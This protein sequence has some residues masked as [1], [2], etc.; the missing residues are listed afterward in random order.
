M[1]D[2]PQNSTLSWQSG[3]PFKADAQ[4]KGRPHRS[5]PSAGHSA[6]LRSAASQTTAYHCTG[7]V[8]E[9]KKFLGPWLVHISFGIF[10]GVVSGYKGASRKSVSHTVR[11]GVAFAARAK[12]GLGWNILLSHGTVLSLRFTHRSVGCLPLAPRKGLRW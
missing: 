12:R 2:S 5:A 10:L 1:S 7:R 8:Q 9:K 11:T 3:I 6:A 4:Q